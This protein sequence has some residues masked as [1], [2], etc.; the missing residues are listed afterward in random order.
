MNWKALGIKFIITMI[1][2]YSIFSI[3][4]NASVL[5]IFWVG[6][7]ATAISYGVGDLFILPRTSNLMAT[8][9]D[10]VL[11]F[12][13]LAVLSSLL[14]EMN[15]QIVLASFF[16]AFILS[17]AEPFV[18]AYMQDRAKAVRKTTPYRRVD[19]QTEFA[20]ETDKETLL[21]KKDP[22]RDQ[23]E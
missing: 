2:V 9:A 21:R 22:R 5:N 6:I 18:H 1:V 20:E 14:I 16:A 13:V 10:L 3:F 4:Y 15:R 11:S 12:A 19:L 7:V 17:T 23:T 8:L